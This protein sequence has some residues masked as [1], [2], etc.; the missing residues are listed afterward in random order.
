MGCR[1]VN[2]S[3]TLKSALVAIGGA[4]VVV[5][6]AAL[7][8]GEVSVQSSLGQPL[9]ASIA[10]SLAPN[11]AISNSCVT[12]RPAGSTS[13]IPTTDRGSLVIADGQ[14][15][16]TSNSAIRE[17]LLNLQVAVNCHYTARY[18]R[19]YMLF[20]DPVIPAPTVAPP[21]ER[22]EVDVARREARVREGGGK[23]TARP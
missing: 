12:V 8:L 11:E 4:L 2:K 5:P 16:I 22:D 3:S 23:R 7:E 21:A 9:R 6:A 18:S 20:I 17:P 13:G 15:N 10:Y 1:K 14:I 19:N